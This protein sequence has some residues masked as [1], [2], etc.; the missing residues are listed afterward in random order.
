MSSD[1]SDATKDEQ[2]RALESKVREL[3]TKLSKREGRQQ[4]LPQDITTEHVA[5][6]A[7]SSQDSFFRRPPP[8]QGLTAEE[9]ER[10]S[11]QLI[12][13]QGFGVS[14]Q[15]KL[16][17]S[18]VLV[19]G[20]G[21]IGSTLL[22][23]LATSGVGQLGIVDFDNV[24]ISN[25]H[26]QV[27][28]R[29]DRVGQNKAASAKQTLEA[30]NPLV[31]YKI[32]ECKVD[33]NNIMNL[34]EQYDCVVDCSDNPKTRYLVNDACILT[35]K[36]LISGSA[37]GLEGQITVYNYQ[38]GPCYRCLYPR[39][40][41]SAGCRSCADAGVFGPV[42]GLIGILQAIE[43]IKVLTGTGSVLSNR[44]LMYDSMQASFLSIKK[45]PKRP[46]CPVCGSAPIIRSMVDSQET[47]VTAVGPQLELTPAAL[48]DDLEVT[49]EA[50]NK[51]RQSSTPHI[52]LDVRVKE[53]Y[54]LCRLP[55]SVHIP[56]DSLTG[57]LDRI[58]RISGG[59]LPIYCVCRRGIASAD[60]T[61]ILN[62]AKVSRLG[63][64]SVFNVKGGLDSWRTSVDPSFPR[65]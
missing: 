32:H 16:L 52:L 1:L 19:I 50:Y 35:N 65:Y 49:C 2:I 43:T 31:S 59:K 63:I 46:K 44:L 51:V 58:E 48:A 40:S 45:P 26:R 11:R 12:L 60:A 4:Q 47:L 34:V 23:Y 38:N 56:L 42:P 24:E 55:D 53:Q 22:M 62:E 14:G 27:I 57:E 20:A 21:G 5:E 15:Q 39:P 28:H 64:H 33:A 41:A 13:S 36:P 25:L 3:E 30:L 61:I 29:T 9:I 8:D 6:E 18:S 17:S 54:E 10:Y 37:V 7:V